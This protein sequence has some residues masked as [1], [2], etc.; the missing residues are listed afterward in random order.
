MTV[1][2]TPYLMMDGSAGEA[3]QFYK[4]VLDAE[5]LAIRTYGEMGGA[6][7]EIKDYVAHAMI[8]VGES[9]LM[10]SDSPDQP[11]QKGNQVTICIS[12]DDSDKAKQFFEAL[13][14][15]G[16]VHHPLE[17]TQFSPAFGN[18]TDKFGVNFTVVTDSQ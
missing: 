18:V 11:P 17:E 8:K 2:L 14:E 1:R 6:P 10:F 13:Q 4:K 15:G 7:E 5:V 12:V 3:I 9:D 16:K